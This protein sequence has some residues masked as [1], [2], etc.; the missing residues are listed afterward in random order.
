MTGTITLD[1][2]LELE[3][4]TD[5][6]GNKAWQIVDAN[7]NRRKLILG[8]AEA[9]VVDGEE[10]SVSDVL[11]APSYPTQADLPSNRPVGFIALIEDQ[12][13]IYFEGA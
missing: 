12:N 4:T 13:R 1:G 3:E 11:D 7:G 10:L 8:E 5:A 6:D 2:E 9:D